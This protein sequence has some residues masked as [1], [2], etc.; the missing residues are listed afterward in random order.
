MDWI[1]FKNQLQKNANLNLQFEYAEGQFV[2]S[3]YH[4]T[5]LKLANITSVDCGGKLDA[6]TEIVVQLWEPAQDNVA[7]SMPIAKALSIIE[8]VEEKILLHPKSTVKI[9]FGNSQFDTRQM[10]PKEFEVIGKNLV[11]NLQADVTQCKA[12]GRGETC[13]PKPKIRI[14]VASE[15]ATA[16]S[17][18]E[19]GSGCC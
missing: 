1:T 9:E 6:W 14:G 7:E 5:E 19:P 3:N 13:G 15:V 10:H 4:I 2:N 11:V 17:C 12:I 16:S 8:K 18:C